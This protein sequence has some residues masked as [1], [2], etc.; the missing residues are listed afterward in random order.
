MDYSISIRVAR[1]ELLL[2]LLLLAA[3]PR[4]HVAAA[5]K[6]TWQDVRRQCIGCPYACTLHSTAHLSS[7]WSFDLWHSSWRPWACHVMDSK[8]LAYIKTMVQYV[9]LLR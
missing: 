5:G 3:W 1:R 8:H 9:Y 7:Q 4:L 2:L 6:P